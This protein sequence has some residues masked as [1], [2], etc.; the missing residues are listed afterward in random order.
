MVMMMMMTMMM[1]LGI[2][3]NN[4]KGEAVHACYLRVNCFLSRQIFAGGF[5]RIIV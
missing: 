2:C 4:R 5:A 1:M 3:E